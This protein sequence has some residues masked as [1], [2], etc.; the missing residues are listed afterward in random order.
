MKVR[1]LVK[2]FLM[3]IIFRLKV[4]MDQMKTEKFCFE[5]FCRFGIIALALR[6]RNTYVYVLEHCLV[7]AIFKP[8]LVGFGS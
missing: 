8:L 4:T 3:G 1:L 6:L 7:F 2:T 5:Y